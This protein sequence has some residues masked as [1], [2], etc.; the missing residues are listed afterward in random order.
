[1]FRIQS[2]DSIYIFAGK[3]LL[4]YLTLFSPSD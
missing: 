2:D 3:N 4:G 1:M